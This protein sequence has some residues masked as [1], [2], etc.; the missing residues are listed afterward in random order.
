[1]GPLSE[2]LYVTYGGNL[3]EAFTPVTVSPN[4]LRWTLGT[5]SGNSL[6]TA[7]FKI[8]VQN[9][10]FVGFKSN[11]AK[12]A[13]ENTE[14]LGYSDREQVSVEFG[15]P[16]IQL[17]KEV[18]G[19]SI[20]AV[21]P[22]E[23]YT[24]S[25]TVTNVQDLEKSVV[26]AFEMNLTDNI[27]EGLT[28]ADNLSASGS[29]SFDD[30]SFDGEN[31]SMLIRKLSPNESVTLSF[32]VNVD[33][34]LGSGEEFIN[35]AVLQRPYSQPDR[36]YQYPGE[37]FIASST[38]K[39]EKIVL[40]KNSNP[41]E[42]K[43]GDVVSY[44]LNITIPKGTIGYNIQVTDTLP[45]TTQLF[46][47]GSAKKDGEAIEPIVNEGVIKF[48]T[49]P[50]VDAVSDS[51]TIVYTFDIRVTNGQ[52]IQ[53][54]I[55]S[56][57]NNALVNWSIDEAGTRT[58][59]V[60]ESVALEVKMPNLIGIKEQR[61]FT[62]E[63]S[64]TT[65]NMQYEIGDIIEYK[66]SISNNGSE[67]AYNAIV[68]EVL[69]PFLQYDE[70]SLISSIGTAN[71]VDG[72][73]TWYIEE[74]D[75]TQEAVLT[76]KVVS[77]PGIAAGDNITNKAS[78]IYSTN[79]N[80]FE[81]T[82]GDNNTNSVKLRVPK[83]NIIKQSSITQGVLGDE[84][85]YTITAIVPQGTI[86]YTPL[87]KDELP[88]NQSY[89]GPSTREEPPDSA[90]EITPTI[91]EQ[92]IEFPINSDIDASY[93][94]KT[95]IYTFTT[96]IINTID[97][98]PYEEI[99][100][101]TSKVQWAINSGESLSKYKEDFLDIVVKTPHIAILKEQ[102]NV[103]I[104]GSFSTNAIYDA[105]A[106]D[107]IEYRIIITNDGTS[108]AYNVVT[109]DKLDSG[110]TY[111]GVRIP[112]PEGEVVSSVPEGNPDGTITWT[113][114]L[115]EI[116]VSKVL[117]F[118][119]RINSGLNAGKEIFNEA[120]AEFDTSQINPITLGPVL[121]N[122]VNLNL[123][124]PKILKSVDRNA[125]LVGD[126]VNYMIEVTIPRKMTAYNIQVS[127]VLLPNQSYVPDSLKRNGDYIIPSQ[128]LAFP[129]EGTI[130][131]GNQKTTIIYTFQASINS[132]NVSPEDA[133]VNISKLNW[134]VEE[135]GTAGS[136]QIDSETVYVTDSN[137]VISKSQKNFT[138]DEE[139]EFTTENIEALVGDV[140]YYKLIV[141][142]PSNTNTLF[143][144]N[145]TDDLDLRVSYNGMIVIPDVG[146]IFHSGDFTGGIIT[147]TI[148]SI[149]PSTS[150]T[151]VI[152]INIRFSENVNRIISNNVKVL[153]SVIDEVTAVVFG[154]IQSNMVDML[155]PYISS[156]EFVLGQSEK[157]EIVTVGEEKRLDLQLTDNPYLSKA[158]IIGYV[159]DLNGNPIQDALVKILNNLKNPLYHALTDDKGKY[160]ITDIVPQS[161]LYIYSVKK[162]YLL[163]GPIIISL[164]PGQ[165]ANVNL[166][167]NSDLAFNKSTITGH[168]V[169]INDNPIENLIVRL[170]K[171]ENEQETEISTTSTNEF[172]QYVFINLD[173]E[174]YTIRIT[175]M[176]YEVNV[177]EISIIEEGSIIN[178]N[179]TMQI[180]P[181]TSNGTVNGQIKDSQGSSIEGAVVI[182]YKVIGTEEDPILIPVRYTRT[183]ENGSYLFGNVPKGRYI[184]KA[185]K[186]K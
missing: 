173:V 181:Q 154:P 135:G 33:S 167:L 156:E 86:A 157:T 81:V 182:L 69:S 114:E 36:S 47:E 83:V 104:G 121:S 142:N 60:N 176:G 64:F 186:E 119:V 13:G 111:T 11:L 79:N 175:G 170:L 125:V 112:F 30:P 116:G 103:S 31:V 95:I 159:T 137:I 98:P 183:I 165:T 73:I 180:A 28:Y 105:A 45:N 34:D 150:Y 102:R 166:K 174:N 185:N 20:N 66:I 143:N 77:L 106:E 27:P 23:T 67:K 8:I 70:G 32:D 68:T 138:K 37:A 15:E 109:S 153:F 46:I 44:S 9:L 113:E 7:T 141:S 41:L 122:K 129:Y 131:S 2:E 14:G 6:W 19:P 53:P 51:V 17:V 162:E 146:E 85:I 63:G 24:Y 38:L 4:G 127:D 59:T 148:D 101:N 171:I 90:V 136:T 100:T 184:V 177:I 149:P 10:D 123:V 107:I 160:Y 87:I 126:I 80:G 84:I 144:V 56:Q 164:A 49:I 62:K 78:F 145:I 133:Q 12:L 52:H 75:I 130:S 118:A 124:L 89:I 88:A 42:T 96:R 91:N 22:E 139:G 132:V 178:I 40:E 25:I 115:L 99:Q 120:S 57:I 163:C 18:N 72:I 172:G 152:S 55:D 97:I 74:L 161:E 35:T 5:I 110:F 147:W 82:Y 169:D 155:L 61:N 50:Y 71:E 117:I 29:G 65:K 92:T 158:S 1:M 93:E 21:K 76:F 54:Y 58:L 108:A 26:D 168:V 140:I 48:S 151:A 134:N 39:S 128:E 16:N 179:T 43:I 94:V 3:G